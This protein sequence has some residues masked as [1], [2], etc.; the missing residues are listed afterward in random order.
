MLAASVAHGQPGRACATRSS[1]PTTCRA[2][3][4]PR[5]RT[6]DVPVG[7]RHVYPN[8]SISRSLK[9][10]AALIHGG[11]ET[12]VFYTTIGGF[13]LHGDAGG[14][15]GSQATLLQNLDDAIGA[16]RDRHEVPMGQWN[17]VVIALF[18]EFGRRNYEN[19]SVGTDHGAA[20]TEMLIGGGVNGGVYGP[21]I[22]DADIAAPKEYLTYGV[23]FRDV[24][25]EIVND[26][27]GA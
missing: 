23:D 15:T 1:R 22:A 8:Q 5:S 19:G 18:T 27:L 7:R 4:R 14:V 25:K 26:H 13:D 17:N 24:C 9:D 20:W 6:A 11:F 16:F 2:R 3:S 10:V 21:S 12:R